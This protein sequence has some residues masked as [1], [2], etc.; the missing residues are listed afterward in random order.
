M[1]RAILVT[2]S[3]MALL[4][5]GA[6]HAAPIPATGGDRK[7]ADRRDLPVEGVIT[8]ADWLSKPTGQD[9]ARFYPPLAQFLTFEGNAIIHCAVTTQGELANC[10]VTSEAPKGMRFGEA[11]IKLAALFRM[12]PMTV[13]GAPVGGG[14]INIP[15]LF[16]LPKSS[17]PNS[18]TALPGPEPSTKAMDL[19][20]RIATMAT[21]QMRTTLAGTADRWKTFMTDISPEET[22]AIE[23][24]KQSLA[25][26]VPQFAERYAAIYAHT[27]SEQE[28]TDIAAFYESASGKA[29]FTRQ[30]GSAAAMQAVGSQ[31]QVAVSSGARAQFCETR[32]C[33]EN[34]P[35][36]PASAR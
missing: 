15:I 14:A 9:F 10:S 3:L 6:G 7:D 24:Y 12:K 34:K 23:A 8:N 18:A 5:P 17:V 19:A 26:T 29:W 31:L 21:G 2:L 22:A 35:A 16:R 33:P 30:P 28:L 36:A 27:Y 4:G 32:G 13:D 20:R 25:Q 11:A 1:N